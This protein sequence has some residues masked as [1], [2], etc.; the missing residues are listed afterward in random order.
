[1]R[2][3]SEIEWNETESEGTCCSSNLAMLPELRDLGSPFGTPAE[4]PTDKTAAS[5]EAVKRSE[6]RHS[7]LAKGESEVRYCDGDITFDWSVDLRT[8]KTSNR[9]GFQRKF[10]LRIGE[11][12]VPF[13]FHIDPVAKELVAAGKSGFVCADKPWPKKR[14]DASTFRRP[15]TYAHLWLRC[16]DPSKLPT[17]KLCMNVS[18]TGG[19]VTR[20][21]S[22]EHDFK[23]H[24]SCNQVVPDAADKLWE[25][26]FDA[27]ESGSWSVNGLFRLAQYGL[28]GEL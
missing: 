23:C 26:P 11:E 22:E 8:A 12:D 6:K 1:M 25:I 18:I 20:H 2:G 3:I 15:G 10:N 5:F 7:T 21:I 24:P 28:V 13:A 14:R 4:I 19:G 17:G 9:C 27:P 16:A